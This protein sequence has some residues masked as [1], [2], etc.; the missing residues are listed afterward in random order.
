MYGRNYELTDYLDQYTREQLGQS[1]QQS[2]AI[3]LP[4]GVPNAGKII[5]A[6]ARSQLTISGLRMIQLNEASA[7]ALYEKERGQTYFN[8]L[9]M[10]ICRAPI[11]A[12]RI[13]GD[14][15]IEKLNQM[16]GPLRAR[17]SGVNNQ[18]QTVLQVAQNALEVQDFTRVLFETK[19]KPTATFKD[20]TCCVIQPHILKEGK[21]GQVIDAVQSQGYMITAMELFNLDRTCAAEF[22]EVYEG[23]VPHFNDAV[24]QL[25][26]GPCVA[27]EVS[28]VRDDDP[29]G[30]F[31]Q[32][33]G[34]WDIEMAKELRP[35]SIRAQFG[36]DRIKNAIHCTDLPQD[37]VLE[38]QYF[39]DIL[40]R[41]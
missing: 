28:G 36:I 39:F 18:L 30:S 6:F 22:L 15:S 26:V 38:S 24:D 14:G 13:V 16:V 19:H 33:A 4:D 1:R 23:V 3:V 8:N 17:Y 34:P 10:P 40:A 27:I 20:C 12:V 35:D 41:R 25:T 37:G 11:I 7:A 2:I 31:R 29:V 21:L 9:I 32:T 5:D